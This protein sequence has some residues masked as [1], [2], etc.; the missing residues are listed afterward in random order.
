MQVKSAIEEALEWIED[1]AEADQEEFEE[2]LKDVQDKVQP[3]VA[4]AYG[5][6]GGAGMD[7]DDDMGDH[8]EL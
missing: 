3:I 6:G 8:D 4:G 5:A 7:E 2:K 1:N